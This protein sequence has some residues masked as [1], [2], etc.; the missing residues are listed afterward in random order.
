MVAVPEVSFELPNGSVTFSVS[1]ATD[2]G[3]VRRVNEDSHFVLPPVVLVADGM[4]GHAYGDRASQA[5][6]EVFGERIRS[7]GPTDPETVLGAIREANERIHA[8]RGPGGEQ[9]L[10]GTTLAGLAF[11]TTGEPERNLWMAFN[12]GD[13][14][15]YAWSDT[16]LQ[17]VTV[18]HSAVQE[19]FEIGAITHAQMATHPERNI[20]TRAVG[21]DTEVDADVWLLPAGGLQSFLICSDGL[22]KE[23]D[24]HLIAKAILEFERE[25]PGDELDGLAELLVTAAVEAGGSDNVTVVAVR[26]RLHGDGGDEDRSMDT[27]EVL[28]HLEQTQ[29]RDQARG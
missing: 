6:V 22:T 29:P 16:G 27:A 26:S 10:A 18:D 14:R 19:L 25:H 23:L 11:V 1:A 2:L 28:E 15:V 3:S 8:I 5:V 17:Q 4:G 21:V 24:D 13:S 9:A 20:I 7:N 12:I